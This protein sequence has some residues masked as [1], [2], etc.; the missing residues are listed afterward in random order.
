MAS[1]YFDIKWHIYNILI[2]AGSYTIP[3]IGG[4]LILVFALSMAV[5]YNRR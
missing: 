1:V 4:E 2:F 3:A 5:C